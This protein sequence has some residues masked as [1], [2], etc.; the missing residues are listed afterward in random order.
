[1]SFTVIFEYGVPLS[2]CTAL[3]AW[4]RRWVE[5]DTAPDYNAALE[6]LTESVVRSGTVPAK[7]NGSALNQLRTNEIALLDLGTNAG[8]PPYWDMREFR[9]NSAGALA[10]T[11]VAQ[12]PDLSLNATAVLAQ[13]V[14]TYAGAIEKDAHSVPEQFPT[15][16][17]FRGGNSLALPPSGSFRG[18]FWTDTTTAPIASREAR[19]HF[20][21]NT[22]NGC[23]AGETA[24]VSTHIS[25]TG[26]S[27]GAPVLSGF[28]TGITVQDPV[29]VAPST[30]TPT[31]RTFN[32]LQRRRATLAA[33][34]N[35]P[36]V[37]EL[38]RPKL[39]MAH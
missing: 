17:P 3:R 16:T 35:R 27:G 39:K 29:T 7:P 26:M 5:L 6:Q 33:I 2:G 24:T 4:A 28:L 10:Q 9:L 13:Y 37:F 12:T 8:K 15:P 32:D 30:P 36:C 38:F 14:N 31:P 1:M 22:C 20:S 25:P 21:L 23:H 34:A 19:F 18:T 11:T